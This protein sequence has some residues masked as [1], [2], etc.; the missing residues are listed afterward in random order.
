MLIDKFYLKT[1]LTFVIASCI[2]L[3]I[4][5]KSEN[6]N[7]NVSYNDNY[8][9]TKPPTPLSG[10]NKKLD[11]YNTGGLE[12]MTIDQLSKIPLSGSK[13][14]VIDIYT[15][16]CGWCKIMDKKTFSDPSVQSFLF[17][18]FHL[19]KFD[20]E[21][22]APVLYKGKEYVYKP[23]G[24]RGNNELALELLNGKMTYPSLVYLDQELNVIKV[25]SGYKNPH[26][27]LQE[28]E[29]VTKS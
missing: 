1:G 4:G 9:P 6:T 17:D 2:V 7:Q 24:R 13:L 20:A 11:V 26:E 27:M 18:N 25:T 8:S 15:T 14:Y 19:I 3:A 22:E 21:R 12:W 10:E 23:G 5:C 29:L 28:L 16:W